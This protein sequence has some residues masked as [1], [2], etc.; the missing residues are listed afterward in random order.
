VAEQLKIDPVL[1]GFIPELLPEERNQ[2]EANI[3]ETGG[4]R[5]ALIAWPHGGHLVLVDG[6]NRYAICEKH[7]LPYKVSRVEFPD[8]AAVEDW[9]DRN[10]LGRRNLSTQQRMLLIGRRY[11][12]TK[13][14]DGGHGDQKSG[15]KSFRPNA[16]ESLAKDHG[17]TEKTVRN[18]GKFQAAAEKLGIEQSIT[19]GSI[20]AAESVVVKA[21]KS[22]PDKP[23][24]IDVKAVVNELTATPK[25][26]RKRPAAEVF[27]SYPPTKCLEA[28]TFYGQQ[29]LERCPAR[30]SELEAAI[31]SLLSDCVGVGS[32]TLIDAIGHVR[33]VGSF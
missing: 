32:S 9:M 13:R 15:G 20:K 21:A 17:V 16:A 6:H 12:R 1:R 29:F 4:A 10:Q 3:I 18:A 23:T 27:K 26:R 31:V 7:G 14:A 25:R 19:S 24:S 30:K 33:P 11:N 22:L 2:L 8:R 5:D 28:M